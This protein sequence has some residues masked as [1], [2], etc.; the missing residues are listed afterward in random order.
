MSIIYANVKLKA[1]LNTMDDI[2]NVEKHYTTSCQGVYPPRNRA[3][4]PA[5]CLLSC[6][7][8]FID[9]FSADNRDQFPQHKE[10]NA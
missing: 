1:K 9:I 8:V 3:G 10:T 5:F 6:I 2:E 7:L 4:N